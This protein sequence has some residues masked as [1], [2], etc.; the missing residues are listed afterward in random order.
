MALGSA[1][2]PDRARPRGLRGARGEVLWAGVAALVAF[3]VAALS[4]RLWQYTPGTPFALGWDNT[5]ISMQLRDV[6][7]HGWYGGT[8]P[9]LGFPLGQNGAWFPELN[10]IHLAVVKV[11]AVLTGDPFTAGAVF[12]VA[13]FP[14]TAV[15]MYLL[16]RSQGLGRPAGLLLGVLLANAPGHQERYG[17]LY[18]AAYW[19]VP[20][21]LWLVL[22]V[23]RGRALLS[24]ARPGR[25]WWRG[26]RTL[27]TVAACLV[28]GLSGVYYVGFTLVL[29]VVAALARRA[30][31]KPA[32]LLRGLGV[33]VALG[34]CIG[35]PLVLARLGTHGD[36]VT[37][38]VPAQRAPA[39]SEIFAG[40]LMDLVLPWPHHRVD[41]LQ[42]VTFAYDA[43]TKAT[44][45]VSALGVVGVAGL[46]GLSVTG[47]LA[48]LAGR[49]LDPDLG[50]W[51]GLTLVS[52]LLYTVGGLG[53]FIAFFATG[54]VRTWS[55][56]SLYIL[57]LALLAVGWWLTRLERRRGLLVAGGLAALLVVVGSLDQTNPAQAPDHRANAA[58]MTDLRAYTAALERSTGGSCGVFQIP[59]LPYPETLGPV[60][61]Q[62]YDQLRP[63]LTGSSMRFSFGAMRGTARADWM[64]AVDSEDVTGLARSLRA[65]GFCALEV[66]TQGFTTEQDP[67]PRLEQALGAPVASTRDGMF[68]TYSLTR[69]GA[70]GDTAARDSLLHPVIASVSAFEPQEVDGTLGQYLGPAAGLDVANLGTAPVD[71]TV[72]LTVRGVGPDRRDV[73]VT[74]GSRQLARVQVT[75]GSPAEVVVRARVA[76]GLT[77]WTV[78]VGGPTDKERGGDR[79]TTAWVTDLRVEARSGVRAVSELAQ[80]GTGWVVP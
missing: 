36:L 72:R 49:R 79:V 60:R 56:M 77:S 18:L 43:T 75:E 21:A 59:V 76:P 1:T 22:E 30:V 63:Y 12:F 41:A 9:D 66:D 13:S 35:I 10:V 29:L 4:L 71:V 40:K 11:L 62:G 68:V 51:S 15:T 8:N 32:D 38:R 27:V 3:V 6:A 58:E 42:F 16:A 39:E 46:V 47:L 65:A 57:T 7:D 55:R 26:G 33:A 67:R 53:S 64:L 20:V 69:A 45:E 24:P 54:Q 37:G 17:H 28:V 52:F 50:R 80:V 78:D 34:T 14:L 19:V 25:P 74:D 48:L 70:A 2:R 44:V 5:Q 61:M 23:A 31:G 73:T